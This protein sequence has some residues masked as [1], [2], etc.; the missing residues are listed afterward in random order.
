MSE[1]EALDL[2]M[3]LFGL[4]GE[5]FSSYL[6][7]TS[8][9]LLVAY[10]VG[11]QLTTPQAVIFN[12]LYIF[13]ACFQVWAI[14]SD[15]L[16]VSELL[17]HKAGLSPLTPF[18]QGVATHSYAFVWLMAAGIIAALYFMWSVRHPRSQ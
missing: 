6:T 11:G 5:N 12:I 13:G 8:G 2:I 18:Q 9:Y 16:A 4:M 1:Y 14:N 10:F 17:V 3:S 15:Q 7:V